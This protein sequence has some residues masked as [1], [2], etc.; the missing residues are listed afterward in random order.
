M[1]KKFT[2]I[3]VLLIFAFALTGCGE[4]S[5]EIEEEEYARKVN[6]LIREFVTVKTEFENFFDGFDQNLVNN[7]NNLRGN[8][9]V[10]EIEE[11][12]DDVAEIINKITNLE[13]PKA[14]Q[15]LHNE[16]VYVLENLE[17]A[18]NDIINSYEERDMRTFASSLQNY[19]RLL[20]DL[21]EVTEGIQSLLPE[22]ER[23]DF[24]SDLDSK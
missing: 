18:K 6:G 3:L 2:C 22:S 24:E 13:A 12:M 14:V 7:L 17:E 21:L 10:E 4:S 8:K 1:K 15:E 11:T 16:L 5:D 9:W 19:Q 20:G 23:T